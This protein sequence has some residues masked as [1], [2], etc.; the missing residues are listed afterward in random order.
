MEGIHPHCRLS[1]RVVLVSFCASRCLPCR[2]AATQKS[3]CTAFTG[4]G[5]NTC[6]FFDKLQTVRTFGVLTVILSGIATVAI[7][8][9]ESKTGKTAAGLANI[10]SRTCIRA[11]LPPCCC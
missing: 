2:I 7:A 5:S 11:C 6:K 8:G 1:D 4:V 9:F 10:A 3:F